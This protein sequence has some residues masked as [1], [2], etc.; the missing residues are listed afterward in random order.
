MTHGRQP[1]AGSIVVGV[2]GSSAAFDALTWAYRQA[3]RT[4]DALH[5]VT[6]YETE[7]PHT[8]YAASYAYAPDG[9][10][11]ARLSEAEARWREERHHL[12][13][14]RAERM[15]HDVLTAV[16]STVQAEPGVTEESEPVVTE[17]SE[18]VVTEEVIAGARPAQILIERSQDAGLLVVGS[19]GLGGFRGLL[20]GSVSQQCVHHASCPVVV[21]RHE[22]Q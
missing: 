5:L 4:G 6:T 2:D 21:V 12:A 9:P 14:E 17:E 8:P 1:G 22:E 19:R 20:L 3:V 15:L 18:P 10:T 13:Q 7:A 11:A 16:R